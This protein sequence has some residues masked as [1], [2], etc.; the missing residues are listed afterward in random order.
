MTDLRRIVSTLSTHLRAGALL[1]C[2]C[3]AGAAYLLIATFSTSPLPAVAVGLLAFGLSIWREQPFA[4]Q[5]PRA[6]MLLHE[7]IGAVEYSLPLLDK[8]QLN[9]AE[10]LQL[11]R[12]GQRA[13]Q[14]RLPNVLW[15]NIGRYSAAFLLALGIHAGYPLLRQRAGNERSERIQTRVAPTRP[16]ALPRLQ[17]ARLTIEPP[18]YTRQPTTRGSDLNVSAVAGS[19]LTWQLRFSRYE[20]VVVQLVNS[21][22]QARPFRVGPAGATYSDQLVQSGLYAI[23]AHGQLPARAGRPARDTVVYQSPFYRLDARPDLPP[24]IEPDT[25]ELYQYHT[26]RDAPTLHIGAKITDDF[27]VARVFLVATVARGS[28]EAVTFREVKLP[29]ADANFKQAHLIKSI[30]LGALNFA[31]G[32]ELYYYWAVVDNRQPEPNLTKSDTY[33]VRYRD[34]TET[35]ASAIATVAVNLMPEY[36]RSQRQ[37]IIDA[38]KLLARRKTM[39]IR[40]FNSAS[41]EIGYDQKVLRLRYGQFLGEEFES[42]AGGGHAGPAD[43]KANPLAGFTHDHDKGEADHEAHPAE[44]HHEHEHSAGSAAQDP[45]A[46][47]MEQYVHQHDN[48]ETNTFHEQSTRALLK[49]ALEQ[50]WQ[51]ELHL[52]LYDPKQA[53]PFAYRALDYLKQSQQ[54]ARSFVQKTGFTPPPI[55][56]AD[57]RLTGERKNVTP[58]FRP[59]RSYA[60]AR[61]SALAAE[62]LG[63]LE[64]AQLTATQR[65][66]VQQL[67][68]RLTNRV[69]NSGLTNWT[70]LTALQKAAAGGPLSSRERTSLNAYLSGIAEEGGSTDHPP[71]NNRRL[72]TAFWRRL[73]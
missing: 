44:D 14:V 65:L 66:A 58:A 71:A 19:R 12:L 35:D 51:S 25:K 31:P 45:V 42:T 32:D 61:L 39:T 2:A 43:D 38:E 27:R 70:V 18:A 63:Y 22:G 15:T 17:S 62:V 73:R 9:I 67:G 60:G 40:A 48:A 52:R 33:F 16:D 68:A 57:V 20:R 56:E 46:A 13:N 4:D 3:V 34:T 1:R 55:N 10:Q 26:R 30:D 49:M 24:T 5:K 36:F 37:I 72:E 7:R 50:M 53:L 23:R 8:S 21:R 59:A 47:L 54:K 41:N 64:A 29:V 69:L 28:G 11:E 6:I